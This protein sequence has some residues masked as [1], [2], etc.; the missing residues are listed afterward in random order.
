[1]VPDSMLVNVSQTEG[2]DMTVTLKTTLS[3][4]Q[5][6]RTH[7]LEGV[8]SSAMQAAKLDESPPLQSRP[9]SGDL[10]SDKRDEKTA[11]RTAER[12]DL[13][14]PLTEVTALNFEVSETS[15]RTGE[16]SSCSV[17]SHETELEPGDEVDYEEDFFE[18][19]KNRR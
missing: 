16:D 4:E 17:V 7:D 6:Q 15:H 18:E 2:R 19:D 3:P 5:K 13:S 8:L 12:A 14:T 10:L 9:Q 1:M 11:S